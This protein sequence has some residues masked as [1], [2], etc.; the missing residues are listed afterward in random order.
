MSPMSPDVMGFQPA[1]SG[2]WVLRSDHGAI[3]VTTEVE[4]TYEKMEAPF[5][6]AALVG[7]IQGEMMN[8]RLRRV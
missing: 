4:V 6:H 3:T 1:A 5:L 2:N 8:P 7:L